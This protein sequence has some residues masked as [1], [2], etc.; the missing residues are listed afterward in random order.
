MSIRKIRVV[1]DPVLRTPC[2]EIREITPAVKHLVEDLL[3]TV[4]DPGRAGLSANQIGVSLRAFSYNIDGRIGYVL[5]PVLETMSGEQYDDEGCLSV[6]GLW[7]K[8]RRANYARV[9]GIDLDGKT[10]VLEGEGLM[11]RML[12]HECDHLDG[13]IYLDR[14][15]KDVRRQALRELRN[16]AV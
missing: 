7:Y 14:L 16:S 5:N 9:R 2:E 12:Q 8:T 11:A 6:P 13:H 15:E 3:E 10:V 1:P 4:N